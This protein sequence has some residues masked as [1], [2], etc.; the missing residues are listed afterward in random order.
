MND[1]L[2][3]EL[4]KTD[5]FPKNK[6]DALYKLCIDNNVITIMDLVNLVK[7]KNV[8]ISSN[9]IKRIVGLI[10]IYAYKYSNYYDDK[11]IDMLNDS[12]KVSNKHYHFNAKKDYERFCYLG[13]S[14]YEVRS[15]FIFSKENKSIIENL[16]DIVLV[17]DLPQYMFNIYNSLIEYYDDYQKIKN[18]NQNANNL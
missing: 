10:K 2:S 5:I 9:L 7:S 6:N 4:E 1:F 3:T 13:L 16:R 11:M 14:F 15:L 12:F 17:E 8:I 18:N